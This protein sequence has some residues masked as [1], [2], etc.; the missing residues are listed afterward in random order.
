MTSDL[1]AEASLCYREAS[2]I[3]SISLDNLKMRKRLGRVN[4]C[5]G[6]WDCYKGQ[7]KN[8]QCQDGDDNENVQKN[9][10]LQVHHALL[11][12]SLPL[13]Y[14]YDEKM[15]NFTFY[16][17]SKLFVLFLK[18]NM[19]LRNLAQKEFACI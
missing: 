10:S 6:F 7:E 9:N 17:G 14:D 15:T 13:L 1:S 5:K 3:T 11:Y 19:V 18:L 2:F 16:G 8:G 4:F 12:I